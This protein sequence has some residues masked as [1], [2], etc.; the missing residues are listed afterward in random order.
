MKRPGLACWLAGRLVAIYQ[1]SDLNSDTP[2]HPHTHT[3]THM[4]S[5]ETE[6]NTTKPQTSAQQ[7]PLQMPVLSFQVAVAVGER[8]RGREAERLRG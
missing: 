6:K 7:A 8:L 3:H 5:S 2:T 1:A 4:H